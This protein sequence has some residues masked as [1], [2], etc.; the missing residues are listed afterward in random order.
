METKLCKD[1]KHCVITT[2]PLFHTLYGD[3]RPFWRRLFGG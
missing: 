1:C 2:N 3:S